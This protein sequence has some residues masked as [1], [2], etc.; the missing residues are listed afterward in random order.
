MNACVKRVDESKGVDQM[1]IVGAAAKFGEATGSCVF[2]LAW[3]GVVLDDLGWHES[4][5]NSWAWFRPLLEVKAV[6]EV[7][8][9]NRLD[10][11]HVHCMVDVARFCIVCL[12]IVFKH[13][14]IQWSVVLVGL[15]VRWPYWV[16]REASA[17][18]VSR[19]F[20]FLEHLI[21]D[22][23]L[24]VLPRLLFDF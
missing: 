16:A 20:K 7:I 18:T 11:I 21:K 5:D 14:L 22:F 6:I 12:Y 1:V 2:D 10:S 9:L 3:L 4:L 23:F 13:E 19:S 8:E 15:Q 24:P 17:L